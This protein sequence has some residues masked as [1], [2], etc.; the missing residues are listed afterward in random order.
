MILEGGYSDH[1]SDLGGKTNFGI[2]QKTL[3]A[4]KTNLKAATLTKPQAKH[5]FKTHYYDTVKQVEDEQTHYH[6]FDICVNSGYGSYMDCKKLTNGDLNKIVQWRIK[7][8][9]SI[10]KN[11]KSQSVFLT[12]WLNRLDRIR[13]FFDK[14]I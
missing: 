7:K 14:S 13:S 1:P 8:Y 5:I 3:D 9:K 11:N 4:L 6:Y 12:G 10:V 2:T